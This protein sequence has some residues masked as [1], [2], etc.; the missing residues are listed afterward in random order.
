MRL[1]ISKDATAGDISSVISLARELTDDPGAVAVETRDG[2][3]VVSVTSNGD[4]IDPI[5]FRSL[6]CIETI[7]ESYLPYRLAIQNATGTERFKI[8]LPSI[9]ATI[10]G[11]DFVVMAGPCAVEDETDLLEIARIAVAAGARLLRGGA[12]KPRTGPYSFQGIGEEGL[13]MLSRVRN[14]TGLGIIT[15]AMEPATVEKVSGVADIV[16]IGSR[17]MQNFP[18]LKEV[19]MGTVP[20][21][22]K[23][24]MSATLEEWLGAAE[25]ILDG[26]NPNVILC[27]RGI[28]TFSRHSRHTLDIGVVP[29]IHER[30]HLPI[31]IDPSH[32]TGAA[33]RVPSMAKAALASGADG[34][35]I[36]IHPNPERAKS[37]GF[38]AITFDQFDKL[39]DELKK[40]ATALGVGI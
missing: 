35:L 27:E 14:E 28:R 5:A 18:L 24:G 7:D 38:Q 21:L 40:I 8:E 37:D 3:M 36:E 16:Q 15:E 11:D 20:V 29:V 22:L 1:I 30:T 10:G 31:I 2:H 34:L 19:G 25:Y 39:M 9:Q 33:S 32:A 4:P 17:N 26:G 23:R 6:G 12:Y 13:E